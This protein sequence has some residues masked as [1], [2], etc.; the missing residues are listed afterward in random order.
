MIAKMDNINHAIIY[1][2]FSNNDQSKNT[3]CAL[4]VKKKK[5]KKNLI[6]IP[7]FFFFF[8]KSFISGKIDNSS[9]RY[10]YI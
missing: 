8:F 4:T 6:I 9:F 7:F 3:Y 5:K 1:L 10:V 2:K